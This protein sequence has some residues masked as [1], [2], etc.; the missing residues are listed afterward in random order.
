M[1]TGREKRAMP[2]IIEF[3][4]NEIIVAS[5]PGN[6]NQYFKQSKINYLYLDNAIAI[7]L[8]TT[9]IQTRGYLIVSVVCVTAAVIYLLDR[10]A[11]VA[12]LIVRRL[13]NVGRDNEIDRR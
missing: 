5:F 9:I 7:S 6:E 13:N 12:C 2:Q 8:A 3:I 1:N 10:S 4:H 11:F